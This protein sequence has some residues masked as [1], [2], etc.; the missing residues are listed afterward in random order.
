MSRFVMGT[1][2]FV[3][4][5]IPL[6]ID[7][8][9]AVLISRDSHGAL[10]VSLEI[11]SPPANHPLFVRSN[12]AESEGAEVSAERDA[13]FVRFAGKSV[14]EVRDVAGVIHLSLDLRPLGLSIYS[15]DKAFHL[16]ASILSGNTIINART[17]ILLSTGER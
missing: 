10:Q 9:P 13:V 14:A 11:K 5:E 4:C 2:T 7:S 1:N 6:M 16:G 15:D 17:G 3:D 8:S 12:V